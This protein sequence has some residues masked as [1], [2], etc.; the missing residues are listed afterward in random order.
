M[1]LSV[2]VEILGTRKTSQQVWLEWT[3]RLVQLKFKLCPSKR[4]VPLGS[5]NFRNH[6]FFF[7]PV[8]FS[9]TRAWVCPPSRWRKAEKR[10]NVPLRS[11]SRFFIILCMCTFRFLLPSGFLI[12]RRNACVTTALTQATVLLTFRGFSIDFPLTSNQK[13][14]YNQQLSSHDCKHIRPR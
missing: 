2:F 8:H 12:S 7:L 10:K 9:A 3:Q 6:D 13:T 11:C 4:S 14:W 1:A 5:E